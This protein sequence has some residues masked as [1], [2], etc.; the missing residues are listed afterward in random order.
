MVEWERFE[1]QQMECYSECFEITAVGE[2]DQL[3]M[4]VTA[5]DYEL[6]TA[7]SSLL[8]MKEQKQTPNQRKMLK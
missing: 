7:Y 6:G 2:T 8:H 5:L 4:E 1:L 3:T